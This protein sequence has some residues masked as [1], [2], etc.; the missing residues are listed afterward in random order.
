MKF[1]VAENQFDLKRI[2][3]NKTPE[4]N[5]ESGFE[6]SDSFCVVVTTDRF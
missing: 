2:T 1:V 6:P 4:L 5:M 3:L